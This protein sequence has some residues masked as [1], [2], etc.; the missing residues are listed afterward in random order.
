ML[1][2]PSLNL[3]SIDAINYTRRSEKEFL[4]RVF[5]R[6]SFLESILDEKKYF[7]IG[8]KGTGKTAYAVLLNNTEY[9]NTSSGIRTITGTDYLKFFHLKESG[10]LR[11]SDY[12]DSWKVI[13]LLLA[14]HQLFESESGVLKFT[15]FENLKKAID[16]YYN[17]A[18]A[19]E[20]VNALEFVQ[21]SELAASIIS[22]HLTAGAK[23]Q[24][25]KTEKGQGLQT[26]LLFIERQMREAIGSLKLSKNHIVFIDGID[27]RPE[28]IE[29]SKYIECI[30]G[31]AQAVWSLNTDF[32]GNIKDSK[33]RI[34]VMLLL[35]PDILDSLGYQNLNAKVRDNG[36]VLDWRTTY[37]DYR[38]SRIFQMV[39]GLLGKQQP[40][41]PFPLGDAW[42][43]YFPFET[44]NLW[45]AERTD[46]PFIGFLRYSFYRPRDIISYLLIMQDYVKLHEPIKVVFTER[47]LKN[48]QAAYSNYLL[49]EVKDHLSFYY[50]GADFDEFTNF[51]QFLKGESRFN[52]DY[53]VRTYNDYRNK[54]S[55]SEITLAALK[56]GPD[57][58]L[59]FLYSLNVVGYDERTNGEEDVFVH[60][61]FR[62][63]SPVTLNP[64]A[65]PGLNF[66]TRGAYFIHPG[67]T[68]ALR[69]GS[70]SR[71][72][73]L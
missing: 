38:G 45:L 58:L 60:W 56:D 61:C 12:V 40:D 27:I 31:L 8:E 13:L 44:P 42:R 21:N 59:Q 7:L 4:S 36:I 33:G 69:V 67:L 51:F 37:Q 25:S 63:R 66:Q 39:D 10:L 16:A 49:G 54:L 50:S 6:D 62:D 5:F 20:V 43:H 26:N 48:C 24:K 73:R 1:P 9:K 65:I 57:A 23:S 41:G 70:A 34:K 29:F 2:I 11:V 53:F 71:A 17:S 28:N 35:R 15:K 19:P 47:S 68:R 22:S 46:D 32:F 55:D 30:K 14:A 64:K 18:F 3:G 72:G 52:W